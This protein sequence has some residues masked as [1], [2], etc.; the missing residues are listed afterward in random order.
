MTYFIV[1]TPYEQC[2]DIFFKDELGYPNFYRMTELLSSPEHA[3]LTLVAPYPTKEAAVLDKIH[4]KISKL[5]VKCLSFGEELDTAFAFD[6]EG[7][8]QVHPQF[9][10]TLT[11]KVGEFLATHQLQAKAG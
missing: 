3:H 2:F 9:K 8:L 7:V 11:H 10:A 6:Q 1:E 5:G 4:Q